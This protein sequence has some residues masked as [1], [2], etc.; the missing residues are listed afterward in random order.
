MA[1]ATNVFRSLIP[2]YRLLTVPVYDYALMT[3]PLSD[4]QLG[5]IGWSGRQGLGDSANLF[6]YYRLTADN[7]ILWGGYDAV[8]HFGRRMKDA[9]ESRPQ[10]HR[11]LAE[12]F[13]T[14]FPQ[15]EGLR[16]SHQW[17]GAIDTSTRFCAFYGLARQGRVAY[18]AGFT[19][20][21]VGATRFAADVMLDLLSGESTPRT[22]LEMVRQAAALPARTDRL[23]RHPDDALVA[24]ARRP[25]RGAAQPVAAHAR[26]GR[27][28]VRL[29]TLGT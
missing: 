1:L 2:R 9:H 18:A 11:L 10:T 19:G 22:E 5:S 15:L 8:Y 6:H 13:F 17:A 21:G 29:L 4:E 23:D 7:R 24:R 20:L 25:A 28:R 12:H 3:E 26:R 14:T 27:A 16:F